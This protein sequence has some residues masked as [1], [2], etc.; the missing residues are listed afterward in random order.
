MREKYDKIIIG[1]GLYGLY[2]TLHCGA[3]K[4]RVIV[5]ECDPEPFRRA[6][7]INQARVHQGYHY[8]RS[9]STAMKSAGYFER[10]HKDFAFC[11]NREFEKIYATSAKYSWSDGRQFKKFCRA[12][13]IPCEEVYPEDYFREGMCDDAFI[14]REY[15]YDAMLLKAYYLDKLSQLTNVRLLFDQNIA[16]IENDGT[17]YICRLSS[18]QE[19]A[20][21]YV[22]NAAYAGTNQVLDLAGFER[23]RIKYELCEIILCDADDR[24]KKCGITVMDGP[25]FS[26]MPFG[27]TGLH[28]LTSVTFTPHTTSY[29]ELPVFACQEASNGFCSRHHLGN[30][31]DCTAKPDSAYAY[32][33]KLAKKY[34]RD[35]LGLHTGPR[36]F[37]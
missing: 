29:E 19:Y 12:A 13:G 9:I 34:L 23:F 2:A 27:K 5:L 26:I 36:C 1:A 15:T 17:D 30:C 31:N 37:R 20:A 10:F 3:K 8:P 35:D 24:L 6:T 18:G 33:E 16:A 28:S 11:I 25:F 32:M 22:L 14:T 7:Y 4:Q 21:P